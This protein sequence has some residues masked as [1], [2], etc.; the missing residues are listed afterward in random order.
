MVLLAV[1][2]PLISGFDTTPEYLKY[3]ASFALQFLFGAV[4]TN[5]AYKSISRTLAERPVVVNVAP[6]KVPE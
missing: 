3:V 5:L 6:E 1:T 2:Y 4:T